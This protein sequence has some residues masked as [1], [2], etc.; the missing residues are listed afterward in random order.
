M[1]KSRIVKLLPTPLLLPLPGHSQLFPCVQHHSHIQLKEVQ[2]ELKAVGRRSEEQ[3]RNAALDKE[4]LEQRSSAE[5]AEL[6]DRLAAQAEKLV[7]VSKDL[8]ESRAEEAK[9][10]EEMKE[11]AAQAEKLV[12]VSKDL[13]ESRAEE[14]KLREEMKEKAAQAEN[15][16]KVSK[17]LEEAYKEEAKQH[18][19]GDLLGAAAGVCVMA[20]A[21]QLGKVRVNARLRP[22]SKREEQAGQHSVL[23]RLDEYTLRHPDTKGGEPKLY[24]FNQVFDHNA[25]QQAMFKDTQPVLN[26]LTLWALA[27]YPPPSPLPSQP[28]PGP[29]PPLQYLIPSVFDGYNELLDVMKKEEG[30]KT[31]KLQVRMLELYRDTLEDLLL[32]ENTR[33]KP[34]LKIRESARGMVMVVKA[35]LIEGVFYVENETLLAV[36]DLQHLQTVVREGMERRIVAPTHMNA[37]SSRS[38]LV[39]SII[40]ETTD[41]LT[42]SVCCGKLSFVDLA[43]SE[44]LDKSGSVVVQQKEA[45]ANNTSLS[46]LVGVFTS[47]AQGKGQGFTYRGNDLTELLSDSLGGN[48]KTLMFVNVS[49]ANGN[50]GETA[51]DRPL[52]ADSPAGAT[53]DGGVLLLEEEGCWRERVAGG[54]GL[55]GHWQKQEEV[56]G[57]RDREVRGQRDREV[58]G[59]RGRGVAGQRDGAVE[60][61]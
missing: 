45:S 21:Q 39:I 30:S 38:H 29:L 14:A 26:V 34:K 3:A 53:A 60:G 50:L 46:A 33:D 24:E 42:N 54:R 40:V 57:Q 2:E 23:E 9:L 13:E 41:L 25:T 7:K 37:E 55:L 36:K 48:A 59:R 43:G 28:T 16:V 17:D 32:P 35:T 11:K 27:P 56:W 51:R 5:Q 10:R 15:L 31:Y 8:E 61:E 52:R 47:L 12:K 4:A 6:V 44:N 19:E 58:G 20:T 49:P 1:A 18:E 22:L